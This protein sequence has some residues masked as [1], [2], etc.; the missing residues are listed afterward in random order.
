MAMSNTKKLTLSTFFEWSI[1]LSNPPVAAKPRSKLASLSLGRSKEA[2]ANEVHNICNLK[3]PRWAPAV[4]EATGQ[5]YIYIHIYIYIY[6]YI[7]IY[8]YTHIYVYIYIYIWANYSNSLTWIKDIWGWF[9]L[10]TM[11]PVRSQWGRYN[12][13]RYIY[14][15][16]Y[17]ICCFML[18]G[19]GCAGSE[20]RRK[21]VWN[22]MNSLQ[23]K[24]G[25]KWWF[26]IITTSTYSNL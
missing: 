24:C 22:H 21:M 25:K 13:P 17:I 9:P 23:T 12:L 14:I 18:F 8:I 5:L 10:L 3:P 1:G 26:K 19:S 7:H 16:Y 20:V 4:H 6:I 15:Y 11:I 2:A